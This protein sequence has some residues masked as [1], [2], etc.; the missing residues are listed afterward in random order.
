MITKLQYTI[1]KVKPT[2]DMMLKRLGSV[3]SLDLLEPLDLLMLGAPKNGGKFTWKPNPKSGSRAFTQPAGLACPFLEANARL[4][5][6]Q[7]ITVIHPTRK[8]VTTDL[9]ATTTNTAYIATATTQQIHDFA[10]RHDFAH[11]VFFTVARGRDTFNIPLVLAMFFYT[12]GTMLSIGDVLALKPENPL[13][14]KLALAG[15]K[16]VREQ[17]DADKERMRIELV[18][19]LKNMS[20]ENRT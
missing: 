14:I 15:G 3:T 18:Q 2:L 6:S 19:E 11:P 16:F 4:S 8:L 10:E 12:Y 17:Q 5:I 9:V 20:L 1:S 13:P 7:G